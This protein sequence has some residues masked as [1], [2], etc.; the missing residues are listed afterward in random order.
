MGFAMISLVIMVLRRNFSGPVFLLC[1]MA[2]IYINSS[3]WAP[4]FSAS[5]GYRAL[6]EFLPLMAV[7]L[8][9]LTGNILKLPPGWLKSGAI[10]VT[11]IIVLYNIQFAFK[12]NST[13]WW[14]WEWSY[15][16]MLR[17]FTF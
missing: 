17:L 5:A 13:V 14:N 15:K 4:T 8:A 10:V 16:T 3:W 1:M 7:P 9:Y 11:W 2:I 12:Y 6:I